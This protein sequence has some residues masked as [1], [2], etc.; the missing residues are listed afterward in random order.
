MIELPNGYYLDA[1][2]LQF[3]LYRYPSRSP[4]SKAKLPPAPVAIGYY[5]TLSQLIT[6]LLER[7]CHLAAS[8]FNTLDAMSKEMAVKMGELEDYMMVLLNAPKERL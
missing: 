1:D 7:E 2:A 6:G 4:E 5:R 8:E 3:I